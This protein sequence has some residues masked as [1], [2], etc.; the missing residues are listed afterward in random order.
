MASTKEGVRH[1]LE[2]GITQAKLLR[3]NRY[4]LE[5]DLISEDMFHKMEISIRMDYDK[6]LHEVK[7]A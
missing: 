5:N 2:R 1:E 6:T 3:L 4:A 7:G